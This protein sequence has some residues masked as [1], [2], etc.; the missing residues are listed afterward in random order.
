MRGS[1][2]EEVV[3]LT[4]DFYLQKNICLVQ[5]IPTPITPVKIDNITRT[6]SLAYFEKQSTVD[7]I[8][9]VQ[10]IPICF[11][12][13]ETEKNYL[14]IKNIHQHQL[15]FM[16]NFKKQQGVSFLIVYF[17][18]YDE[19]HFVSLE[20]L[21]NLI[22]LATETNRKSIKYELFDKKFIITKNNNGTINYLDALNIY[23]E[24]E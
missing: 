9:V 20:T 2:L 11:D 17:K 15:E 14:P 18:L 5:K 7:Y 6:I 4:N 21:E 23:F 8:G 22:E 3:N 12:A 13:K 10:G 24:S 19:Y 1:F 16:H